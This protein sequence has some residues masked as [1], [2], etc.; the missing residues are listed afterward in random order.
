MMLNPLAEVRI[1]VLMPIRISCGQ[2]MVHV[3]GNGKRSKHKEDTDHPQYH[4]HTE[5][6]NEARGLYRQRHHDVRM[7]T[8]V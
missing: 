6:T 8:P 4:S 1:R 7:R 5:Q 3:Q 2:L